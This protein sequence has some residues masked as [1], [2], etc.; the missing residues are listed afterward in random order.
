LFGLILNEVC[1]ALLVSEEEGPFG[2][3][4]FTSISLLVSTLL[5]A[6]AIKLL[7]LLLISLIVCFLCERNV[8]AK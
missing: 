7:P 5:K 3:D 1:P 4:L 2:V 6:F 8:L